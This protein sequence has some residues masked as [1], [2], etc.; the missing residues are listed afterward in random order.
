MFNFYKKLPTKKLKLG[1]INK[2][3]SKINKDGQLDLTPVI[4]NDFFPE[5]IEILRQKIP[6][7]KI[8]TGVTKYE[9]L[10]FSKK[11]FF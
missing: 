11:I 6:T 4:D 8:L 10:I 9:S 3:G 2:F 5:T 1:I 7:K